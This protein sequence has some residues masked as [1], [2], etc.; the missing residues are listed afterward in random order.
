MAKNAKKPRVPLPNP[1]GL[2]TWR[3]TVRCQLSTLKGP[4]YSH[5][6]AS[7][8]PTLLRPRVTGG[9]SL[10]GSGL[11]VAGGKRHVTV[12]LSMGDTWAA[13]LASME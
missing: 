4:G 1:A 2:S 5:E 6:S 9:V 10:S 11:D 13:P 8:L 7:C 3:R 12:G